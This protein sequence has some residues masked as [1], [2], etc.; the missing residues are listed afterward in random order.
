M[1]PSD[2]D[3]IKIVH[4]ENQADIEIINRK[5]HRVLKRAAIRRLVTAMSYGA[6][7]VEADGVVQEVYLDA[8]RKGIKG[9]D[10]TLLHYL[11]GM[12][13]FKVIDRLRKRHSYVELNETLEAGRVDLEKEYENKERLE[14]ARSRMSPKEQE[15][16]ERFAEGQSVKE[17]AD[18][19]GVREG[20][21]RSTKNR[22]KT[23]LKKSEED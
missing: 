7:E 2:E 8:W 12:V 9:V 6:A 18:D 21:L 4:P 11:L 14:R 17:I 20:A 1:N 16:F 19:W 13:R 5:Y 3:P 22:A 23:R 15:L 10:K